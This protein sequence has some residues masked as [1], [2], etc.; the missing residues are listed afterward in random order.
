[1][2]A[3]R[4]HTTVATVTFDFPGQWLTATAQTRVSLESISLLFAE[5]AIG[6][7][8]NEAALHDPGQTRDLE[9]ALP[10]FYA[11]T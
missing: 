3:R 6:A 4:R 11:F 2:H 10:S 7:E 8:P 5:S 1:M 9:G